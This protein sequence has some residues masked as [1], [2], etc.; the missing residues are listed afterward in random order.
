LTRPSQRFVVRVHRAVFDT[1][2]FV[3]AV[4]NPRGLWG[5]LVFMHHQRYELVVSPQI[6]REV[7]E[8]IQR[9]RIKSRARGSRQASVERLEL[10]LGAAMQV[11]VAEIPPVSRDPKDDVFLATAAV[12][13]ADFLVSEDNDLLVLGTHGGVRIVTAAAFLDVLDQGGR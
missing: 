4:L 8:V 5:R 2:V 7:L 13:G 1:V 9:P 10:I 6:V 12:A 3:R 11:V